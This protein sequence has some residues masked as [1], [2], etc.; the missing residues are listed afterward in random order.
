M[1][2]VIGIRKE[3][4]E[5]VAPLALKKPHVSPCPLQALGG[6]EGKPETEDQTRMMTVD[7]CQ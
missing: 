7:M 4:G 6:Y 1:A 5:T 2:A 3:I